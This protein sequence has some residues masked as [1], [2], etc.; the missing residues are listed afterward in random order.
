MMDGVWR[1]KIHQLTL[2]GLRL[3]RNS[4]LMIIKL[5]ESL[6]HS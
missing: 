4:V 5:Q 6:R 3:A 2:K 1:K